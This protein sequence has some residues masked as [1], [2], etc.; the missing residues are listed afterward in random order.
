MTACDRFINSIKQLSSNSNAIICFTKHFPH[1]H[2]SMGIL[3][4]IV[5]L[6]PNKQNLNLIHQCAEGTV[7]S[8]HRV[9]RHSPAL[10]ILFFLGNI[11]FN[12]VVYSRFFFLYKLQTLSLLTP[13]I[14]ESNFTPTSSK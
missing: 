2:W 4:P 14:Q 7:F 6:F 5:T 12:L 13:H 8:V 9:H 1:F 3:K 11:Y 10:K